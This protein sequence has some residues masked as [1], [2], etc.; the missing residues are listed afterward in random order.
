MRSEVREEHLDTLVADAHSLSGTR[1]ALCRPESI[2]GEEDAESSISKLPGLSMPSPDLAKGLAHIDQA[3]NK[4]L[5]LAEGSE[6][7][8]KN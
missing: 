2:L 3:R 4:I 1:I 6:E 8:Q 7:S 5:N